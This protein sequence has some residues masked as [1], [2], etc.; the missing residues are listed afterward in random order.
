MGPFSLARSCDGV[1]RIRIAEGTSLAC[2][3]TSNIL[4]QERFNWLR[5]IFGKWGEGRAKR[6][7]PGGSRFAVD[8]LELVGARME[9]ESSV[10]FFFLSCKSLNFAA[11]DVR[12]LE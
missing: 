7:N 3:L 4:Q 6:R 11:F 1:Y 5:V 8:D 10:L 9:K 12:L 2:S